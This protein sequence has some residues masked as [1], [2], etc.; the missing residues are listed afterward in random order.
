[1]KRV[2]LLLVLAVVLVVGVVVFAADGEVEGLSKLRIAITTVG[3]GIIG[4]PLTQ[5][6]KRIMPD[7]IG[8]TLMTYVTYAVAFVVA[9]IVFAA[10]GGWS[11]LVSSPLSILGEGSAVFAIMTLAYKTINKKLHLKS[12]EGS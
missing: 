10:T 2:V 12:S 9:V 3:A 4:V 11:T 8:K 6:V 7:G 5:L 1:M